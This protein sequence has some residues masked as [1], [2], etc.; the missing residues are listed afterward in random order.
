MG[1]NQNSIADLVQLGEDVTST[2]ACFLLHIRPEKL[3]EYVEVHQRVWPDMLE[4]LSRNGWRNYTLFLR[5]EDG[6]VVGYFESDDVAAAQ[7]AMN[8]DPINERWQAEMAQYFVEGSVQE[9]LLPYFR[10]A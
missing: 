8:A 2:R 3:A 6:L 10:L 9:G 4:A 1:T 7:A 5:E